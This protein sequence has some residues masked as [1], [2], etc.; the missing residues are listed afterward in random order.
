M[1]KT[2]N[3]LVKVGSKLNLGC[4]KK[5]IPNWVNV[6][7]QKGKGVDKSFDFN[8][9]PYPLKENTFSLILLDN[10]LEHLNDPKRVLEEL[11]R[12]S[13]S[14]GKIIIKVPYYHCKG[15][16]NDITHKHFFNET[17]FDNLINPE[18]HYGLD[19]IPQNKKFKIE[20]L[21]L[22]PTRLGKL[23]P[24]FLRRQASYVLGEIFKEIEVHLIVLKS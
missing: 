22:T 8:K 16:Y 3:N 11:H 2:K 13:L 18:N 17:T 23:I 7:I 20:T 12:L 15:A 4:G 24:Y 5:I 19:A 6:D 9:F 10:V 1:N 21:R 14:E